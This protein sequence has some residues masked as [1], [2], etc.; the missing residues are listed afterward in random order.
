MTYTIGEMAKRLNISSSTLRYYD[1]EGLLP[2][3]ERKSSGIR[4]FK[5]KDIEYLKIIECL[6]KAGMSIKDIKRYIELTLDGDKTIDERLKMFEDKKRELE[7][8]L[9][10]LK[11]TI[12]VIDYKCWFY[13]N[14]KEN[15]TI[16]VPQNMTID[17]VPKEYK[18]IRR[19]LK[20]LDNKII[21][22]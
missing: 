9:S 15:G 3:V 1:K 18:E 16:E 22:H 19:E 4:V 21:S 2:F 14:A 11:H 17:D 8:Q 7:A 20:L 12:K 5:E 13:R 6:K 10:E